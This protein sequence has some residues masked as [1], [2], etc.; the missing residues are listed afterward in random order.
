MLFKCETCETLFKK[1]SHLNDHI[2]NKHES[3][4]E[5]NCTNC[6]KKYRQMN[7]FV[8][9]FKKEHLPKCPKK[10]CNSKK[11]CKTCEKP[12][13]T[14]KKAWIESGI[15]TNSEQKKVFVSSREL[16]VL[17]IQTKYC[18][19]QSEYSHKCQSCDGVFKEASHLN[20]HIANVHE[21]TGERSCTKC[22]KKECNSKKLCKKCEEPLNTAKKTWME[23]E[24]RQ[25][26]DRKKV[27]LITSR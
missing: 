13:N 18:L 14:A 24:I 1:A 9:H 15:Q 26:P 4:G 3:T 2:A 6:A 7:N 12:L 17:E 11:L 5:R 23:P 16:I 20:D 25:N 27:S 21:S 8:V 22:R 19:F 10:N